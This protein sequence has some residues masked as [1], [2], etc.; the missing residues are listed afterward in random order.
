VYSP[1]YKILEGYFDIFE[2]VGVQEEV[3]FIYWFL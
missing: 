3:S 1:K 2:N